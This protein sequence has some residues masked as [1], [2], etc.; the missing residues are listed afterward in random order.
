MGLWCCG[1]SEDDTQPDK[2]GGEEQPTDTVEV[3]PPKDTVEIPSEED[4]YRMKVMSYNVRYDNNT[5]FG[6]D[7]WSGIRKERAVKLLKEQKPDFVGMQEVLHNQL[8]DLTLALTDYAYVGVGRDDGKKAGEYAPILYRKDRFDLMKSG[9]F[10]Y[11]GTPDK[12]SNDWGAACIRICTW[13]KLKDKQSGK[14]FYVLNSHYD[15]VSSE[16]RKK[17]AELM[18]KKINEITELLPVICTGDFNAGPDD[19]AISQITETG[20]LKDAYKKA[21]KRSG[22]T[23]TFHNYDGKPGISRIDFL[24]VTM[25]FKVKSYTT[26]DGEIDNYYP[27]D[28][29]PVL[30]ETELR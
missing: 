23:N 21:E 3:N 29:F 20:L 16:A 19:P 25:E 10:W 27:S 26:L 2:P 12:P 18:L 5:I 13:A 4:A 17:S 9:H 30:I 28:H 1:G 8:M 24:F 11:S 7:S 15:H 14:E 6:K 22:C